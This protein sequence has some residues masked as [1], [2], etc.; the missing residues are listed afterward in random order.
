MRNRGLRGVQPCELEPAP[1]TKPVAAPLRKRKAS[2][3]Y[4][5]SGEWMQTDI[6]GNEFDLSPFWLKAFWA[7]AKQTP[8]DLPRLQRIQTS[9]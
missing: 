4:D 3:P 2:T 1:A 6:A 8:H 5:V 9:E 7:Q